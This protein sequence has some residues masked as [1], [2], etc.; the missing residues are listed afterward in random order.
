M[1]TGKK[2]LNEV[3]QCSTNGI[4]SPEMGFSSGIRSYMTARMSVEFEMAR[5]QGYWECS[6]NEDSDDHHLLSRLTEAKVNSHDVKRVPM[7]MIVLH[8]KAMRQAKVISWHNCLFLVIFPSSHQSSYLSFV[9]LFTLFY[10]LR[11]MTL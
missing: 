9:S 1:E 10:F 4:G 11:V 7:R 3:F 6:R 5:G 2:C 8:Y